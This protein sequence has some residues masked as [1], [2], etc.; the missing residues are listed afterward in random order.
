[1][2]VRKAVDLGTVRHVLVSSPKRCSQMSVGMLYLQ[3]EKQKEKE[4][5]IE[6]VKQ[7]TKSQHVND[8]ALKKEAEAAEK[9]AR[10]KARGKINPLIEIEKSRLD[11]P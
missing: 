10:S 6:A 11:L 4:A 1:M 9:R 3:E 8:A 2:L 7:N 5:E